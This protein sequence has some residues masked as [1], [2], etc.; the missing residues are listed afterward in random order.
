MEALEHQYFCQDWNL[1]LLPYVNSFMKKLVTEAVCCSQFLDPLNKRLLDLATTT[2]D[3]PQIRSN[4]SY[5]GYGGL[6]L[7]TLGNKSIPSFANC[8]HLDH[9]DRNVYLKN[10]V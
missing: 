10:H 7:L 3:D 2:Y 1:S 4:R 9:K 8:G 5:R 6:E